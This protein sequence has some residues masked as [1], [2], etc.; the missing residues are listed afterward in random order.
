MAAVSKPV[1]LVEFGEHLG[2][3]LGPWHTPVKLDDVAKLACERTAA[4]E[5]DADIQIVI[6]FKKVETGNGGPGHV[7]LEFLRLEDSLA[8]ARFPGFNKPVNDT[9]CFAKH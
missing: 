1:E 3:R 7:G 4:R 6:E 8:H 9:L 2:C 5:L